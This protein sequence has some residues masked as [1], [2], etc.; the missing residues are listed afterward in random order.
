MRSPLPKTCKSRRSKYRC[1]RR[2]RPLKPTKC[3]KNQWNRYVRGARYVMSEHCYCCNCY[4]V[5][6]KTTTIHVDKFC[7]YKYE[8]TDRLPSC[9]CNDSDL[10]G[11][12]GGGGLGANNVPA[13]SSRTHQ[14][15]KKPRLHTCAGSRIGS[16]PAMSP[17][18]A[19]SLSALLV[20]RQGG[21]RLT[22]VLGTFLTFRYEDVEDALFATRV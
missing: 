1:H 10:P 3:C 11:E 4:T 12:G 18:L 2:F 21:I 16:E 19:V 14:C 22:P 8:L 15:L 9:V 6:V 20:L 13:A 5:I 7:L 17:W